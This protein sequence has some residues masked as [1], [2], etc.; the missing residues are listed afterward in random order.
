MEVIY[1]SDYYVPSY[2]VMT[3]SELCAGE[4]YA[5]F[6][7][8]GD[9][10]SFTYPMGV[11]SRD[12][13]LIE[14]IEDYKSRAHVDVLPETGESHLIIITD[15]IGG[16]HEGDK[17]KAYANGQLVGAINIVS[18]H[19]DGIYDIDLFVDMSIYGGPVLPGYIKGDAIDLKYFKHGI[20]QDITFSLSDGQ[21]GE[22]TQLTTGSITITDDVSPSQFGITGNYPNPFNPDTKI[23]Y[24]VEASGHVT[25][26][27]YDIMGRLVKTLV[28]EHKESG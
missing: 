19:M 24:N 6:L 12:Y 28:D 3:L 4:A 10:I 18:E 16:M 11:T 14:D 13:S 27:I 15:V 5:V 9:D 7:N 26:K 22:D 23:E 21:Y 17:I 25:L 1:G 20:E 2:N 8:G